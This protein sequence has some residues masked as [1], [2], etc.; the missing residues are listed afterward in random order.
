MFATGLAAT[1]IRDPITLMVPLIWAAANEDPASEI[2]SPDVPRSSVMDGVPMYAFDKHTRIGRE[3]I[4]DLIKYNFA[5]RECLNR[6][7]V[8]A[9]RNDAAYMAA[10]YADA[11]PLAR[12]LVWR[13]A[14]ELESLGTDPR[15]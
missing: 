9:Q 2:I 14:D 11:A 15:A 12:K 13:G 6:F 7:V 1:K 5:I 8:P 3:A 10:F 4:R